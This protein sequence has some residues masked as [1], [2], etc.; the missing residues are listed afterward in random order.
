VDDCLVITPTRERPANAARLMLAVH[1]TAV[2]RTR[3][4]LAVDDDDPQ[5]AAYERDVRPLLAPGD[6]MLV[7]PRGCLSQ[8]TNRV[9][10]GWGSE[11]HFLASLGDDHEPFTLGW[12]QLLADAI[13]DLPGGH[14]FAYPDDERRDD[15]PEAV[16][17]S[18]GI[19]QALG[20]FMLPDCRHFYVDNAW[21]DLGVA[22]GI[23]YVHRAKVPHRHY[24]TTPGVARDGSYAQA[25][26]WGPADQAAYVAW[27]DGGGLSAAV[28]RVRAALDGKAMT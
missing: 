20:W 14:G 27:R 3:V 21:S 25:E 8:W 10:R 1:G 11:Y 26:A 22:L 28:G 17:V 23:S 15:I 6:M 18:R 12:D 24:T 2:M 7:A 9:A 16:M 19:V 5:L 13:L 4:A